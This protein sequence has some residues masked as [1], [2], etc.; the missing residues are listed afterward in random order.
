MLSTLS[1]QQW[2]PEELTLVGDLVL[3]PDML[4]ALVV[5]LRQTIAHGC[6]EG[7]TG[8]PD[9]SSLEHCRVLQYW[10]H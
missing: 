2:V 4:D 8:C 10:F 5:K 6:Y 9:C 3:T 7:E 1:R